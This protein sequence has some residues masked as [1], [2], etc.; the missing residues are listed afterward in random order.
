LD[1]EVCEERGHAFDRI[2]V[3]VHYEDTYARF[4]HGFEKW[5]WPTA[6]RPIC[7]SGH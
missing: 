1:A 3:I 6:R 7:Q 4:G 5:L 2:Y